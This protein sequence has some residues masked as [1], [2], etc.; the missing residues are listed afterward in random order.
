MDIGASA[1]YADDALVAS[2][3]NYG[4]ETVD[5]FAPMVIECFHQRLTILIPHIVVLVWQRLWSQ[6]LLLWYGPITLIYLQ[7]S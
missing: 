6:E 5:V 3:S 1:K 4:Q 7:L 2:F